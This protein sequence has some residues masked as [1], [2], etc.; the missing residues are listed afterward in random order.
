MVQKCPG[1]RYGLVVRSMPRML[2]LN[3]H[4]DTNTFSHT[5]PYSLTHLHTYTRTLS[6]THTHTYTLTHTLTQTF[7]H[8]YTYTHIQSLSHTHSYPHTQKEG[9]CRAIQQEHCLS[10]SKVYRLKYSHTMVY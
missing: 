3:T 4:K 2:P 7:T 1:L 9:L 8:F 10:Y 6:H 5:L